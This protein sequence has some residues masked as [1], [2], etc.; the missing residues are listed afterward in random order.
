MLRRCKD[1]RD[2][3]GL[4]RQ[5]ALWLL[6]VWAASAVYIYPFVDRGWVPHDEGLIG[7]S[8][9]RVLSGQL[10]HRDFDETYTGGLSYLHAVAFKLAGVRL[11]S[12]P[13][14]PAGLL[15]RVDSSA[16]CHRST[17]C[18]A[19]AGGAG[20]VARG[21]V[22]HAELLRQHALLVQPDLRHLWHRR[23]HEYVEGGGRW[24]LFAAGPLAERCSPS[25]QPRSTTSWGQR[26]SLRLASWSS[27]RYRRRSRSYAMLG[28]KAAG[29]VLVT[30]AAIFLF[31][32]IGRFWSLPTS[33]CRLRPP[34]RCVVGSK[35]SGVGAPRP[36]AFDGWP[37]R[38][39]HSRRDPP[40][41]CRARHPIWTVRIGFRAV[42][43]RLRHTAATSGRGQPCPSVFGDAAARDALCG[44]AGGAC[45]TGWVARFPMVRADSRAGTSQRCSRGRIGYR[46]IRFCGI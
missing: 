6:L 30:I 24:W 32:R 39:L 20:D 11:I 45:W 5:A 29:A 37:E 28:A 36:G 18:L 1:I 43:R 17:A 31:A 4:T 35:R 14:H 10:P 40:A 25:S 13:L 44:R 3:F 16:V 42:A 12:A 22:G 46:V 15:P 26:C 8:A 41:A 38:S 9:E 23:H 34:R 19:A 2:L 33:L 21:H 7:Q 27:P